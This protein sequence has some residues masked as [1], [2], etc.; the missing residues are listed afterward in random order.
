VVRFSWGGVFAG[1][2][3]NPVMYLAGELRGETTVKRQTGEDGSGVVFYEGDRENTSLLGSDA[4]VLEGD[5][6]PR[7]VTYGSGGQTP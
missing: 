2:L 4:P 1:F 7:T 3:P 5:G 6:Y